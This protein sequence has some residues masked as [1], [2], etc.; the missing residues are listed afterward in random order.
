[1]PL[2]KL[3]F[4]SYFLKSLR[5]HKVPFTLE[6]RATFPA[7]RQ[8]HTYHHMKFLRLKRYVRSVNVAKTTVY[9]RTI[10]ILGGYVLDAFLKPWTL[11]IKSVGLVLAVA[12][13][14][15]LGKEV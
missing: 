12:S 11:L 7:F 8:I 1:M 4:Q 3:G 9:L 5:N 13:G 6:V 2:S 10:K 14:L 15:S